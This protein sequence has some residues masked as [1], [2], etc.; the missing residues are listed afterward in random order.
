MP[1]QRAHAHAESR[2][3]ARKALASALAGCLMIAALGVEA[4]SAAAT[5]RGRVGSAATPAS[6]AEVTVTNTATGL[7]RRTTSNASGS[8]SLGGL[9]PG[10][11]RVEVALDGETSSQVQV[12]QTATVNLAATPAPA[13]GDARELEAIEITATPVFETKTSEVATYISQEQIEALPQ[14]SRNFLSFA[15]IVPGIQVDVDPNDGSTRL[16][17]GAQATNGINVYIDGVGQKNYVLKG[18]ITGQDSSRGN[19]FPQSAIAE[20]KVITSNYKAE[21]DQLSSAAIVAV[22]RSGTNAFEGGVFYDR[23]DED[24]RASTPRELDNGKKTESLDEQYGLTFG[25]PLIEDKLHFFF[26]YEAKDRVDPRDVTPGEN[27]EIEDLPADA[28]T[29]MRIA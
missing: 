23:T 17:G 3:P 29:E 14:V 13:P 9:P 18:G 21:F 8:Y 12:A 15:D 7:T 19:P 6:N 5:L 28:A 4:Q 16:R 10:T 20:Y 24:W 27:V 26:A 11:Y 2:G 22:T 1:N 25:G